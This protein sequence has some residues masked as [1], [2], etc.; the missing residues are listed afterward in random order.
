ML[1][2]YCKL[3]IL[4]H[5]PTG[6]W[7]S[8]LIHKIYSG[9]SS[10]H[11]LYTLFRDRSYFIWWRLEP[12]IMYSVMYSALGCREYYV[13]FDYVFNAFMI[14]VN[15]IFCISFILSVCLCL[16]MTHRKTDGYKRTNN[17]HWYRQLCKRIKSVV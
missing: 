4:P 16:H 14:N 12:K 1:Y 11:R 17:W 10:Y 9:V 6:S 3:Y 2:I 15:W 13:H 8:N 7:C 5:C